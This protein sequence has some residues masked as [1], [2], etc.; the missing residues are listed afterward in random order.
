[1]DLDKDQE[2][3]VE[4]L[5]L[6]MGAGVG[7]E[8]IAEAMIEAGWRRVPEATDIGEL[9][10]FEHEYRTRLAAYIRLQIKQLEPK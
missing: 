1:M 3:L 7:P 10:K 5:Y 2:A 9:R 6:A 4:L 8:G